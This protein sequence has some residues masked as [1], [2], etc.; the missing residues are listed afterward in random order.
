[1]STDTADT[2]P[3]AHPEPTPPPLSDEELTLIG[4]VANNAMCEG[5]CG[6]CRYDG[7]R[8]ALCLERLGFTI[9]RKP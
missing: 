7:G 2:A 4:R 3:L 5:G 9:A 8:I 6:L 1:M